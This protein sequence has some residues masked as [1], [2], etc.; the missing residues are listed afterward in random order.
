M[1]KIKLYLDQLDNGWVLQDETDTQNSSTEIVE[2]KDIRY[3][4]GLAIF[5]YMRSAMDEVASNGCEIELTVSAMPSRLIKTEQKPIERKDFISIPF[6]TDS[7]FIKEAI[8]IPDGCVAA[9]E[10]RK[11]FIRKL[12]P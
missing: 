3:Q 11:I 2:D 6:G 9:I 4:I 10:G 7:E 12:K 1:E 8:A 5:D